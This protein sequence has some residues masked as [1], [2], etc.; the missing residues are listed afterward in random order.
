MENSI[1]KRM[2]EIKKNRDEIDIKDQKSFFQKVS[3]DE[4]IFGTPD[5]A[6]GKRLIRM[7]E[8]VKEGKA[9]EKEATM[10]KLFTAYYYNA[11]GGASMDCV[12]ERACQYLCDYINKDYSVKPT[13]DDEY[14][15]LHR[16]KL[17]T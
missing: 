7:I 6:Y 8:A 2:K 17:V 5:N 16:T 14:N 1:D 3:Q 15:T 10:F 13:M 4:W 9:T 11:R 12:A